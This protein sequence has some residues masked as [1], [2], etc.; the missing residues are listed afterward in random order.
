M[1]AGFIAENRLEQILHPFKA[2]PAAG[3]LVKIAPLRPSIETASLSAPFF[4]SKPP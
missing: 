1:G 4:I 2:S 3:R